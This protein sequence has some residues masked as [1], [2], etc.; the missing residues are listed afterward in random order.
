MSYRSWIIL[1]S[2][3]LLFITASYSG[4]QT[5]RP[6]TLED[7]WAVKRVG[8]PS[9][10]PTAQWAAVE[11]TTY[12][13]DENSSTSDIWLLSTDG[14]TQRQLTSHAARDS[15]P[16]WSPDGK[17]IAF[18]SRREGDDTAQI[19]LISPGGGEARRL[20]RISS[21][22]GSIKWLNDS[23][24]IA[25]LS[26]VWPD[27]TTDA[28]QARRARERAASKMKAVVIEQTMYRYWDHWISDG[29]VPHVF[30]ASVASGEIRDV[31]AGTGL[32]LSLTDISAGD[33]DFSPDG[34]ELAIAADLAKDPG[35][36]PNPD[37]ITVNL[38]SKA[39]KNITEENKAAD[40][41]PRYS[42]DG[43]FIAY[44]R[45]RI[46]R[47]EASNQ[48][49]TLYDRA[50]G[51]HK[52]L[53]AAWDR[54]VSSI[55]WSAHGNA[56]Y[57]N[58][59]DKARVHLW[60]IDA[61]GGTPRVVVNGGTVGGY[62]VASNNRMFV[63]VNTTMEKPAAVY[64]ANVEGDTT[65][66]IKLES[67]ND[68][69]ARQWKFGEVKDVLFKGWNDEP[70]QMWVIY[71]PDFDPSKK[72]PL[73][74]AVHGGP[75]GEWLDQFHF[76]WNMH[77]LASKGYVVAAVNFHGS[78]GRGEKFADS[79]TG[80]FGRKEL[81]DTEKATDYLLNTGYIDA[82]RLVAA[83]GSFGGFMVAYMNGNSQRYKAY[84]CH[85]GV[86]DY[87]FQQTAS[88][89]V[90][91]RDRA[92]G[93]WFWENADIGKQSARNYTANMKTPTLIIHGELDYRVPIAQ[94]FAYYGALKMKQVPARLLYFPD[95]NHWVLKPQNSRLWHSEVF[96]WL[97]QYAPP[98]PR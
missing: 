84:V 4:A 38:A 65:E 81:A 57:F 91:S 59:E 77:L 14:K 8:A 31:L 19:Y 30:V 69:L 11:V 17:W 48:V 10:D 90:R 60:V 94:A 61:T 87:P 22:A 13:M 98:G 50:T 86:Y 72:W 62:S 97:G 40:G 34:S 27:L 5:K 9:L 79:I 71:P 63:Y 26:Q 92:L 52:L 2:A 54:A 16:Q 56:L 49:L 55:T 28:E 95:E 39:W 18:T 74:H 73:L 36:D 47:F 76:R 93:G 21:G 1:R 7:L 42:P 33:Y 43:K 75:H 68:A 44:E 29:R 66:V 20:T 25:F 6:I 67:F 78:T 35:F 3:L 58:A 88:D 64:A 70:V 83:G 53:T 12:S 24:G 89:T 32:H 80:D 41:G 23:Q 45:T 15:G 82:E 96:A 37:I 85:D 46:A 51:T